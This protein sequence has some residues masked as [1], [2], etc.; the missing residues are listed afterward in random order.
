MLYSTSQCPM[1]YY[2]LVHCTMYMDFDLCFQNSILIRTG[3]ILSFYYVS[4]KESDES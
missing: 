3:L 4:S 2:V 1:Q